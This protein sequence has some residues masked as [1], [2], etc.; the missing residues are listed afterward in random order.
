MYFTYHSASFAPQ[1]YRDWANQKQSLEKSW[2]VAGETHGS[3]LFLG[4]SLGQVFTQQLDEVVSSG[5]Q[6]FGLRLLV[7]VIWQ[8]LGNRKV[9]MISHWCGSMTMTMTVTFRGLCQTDK[10]KKLYDQCGLLPTTAFLKKYFLFNSKY[11]FHLKDLM[12]APV[13]QWRIHVTNLKVHCLKSVLIYHFY[14]GKGLS[15]AQ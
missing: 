8:K 15:S 4:F 14:Y 12:S 10:Q 5:L 6:L 7:R 13:K 9:K 11:F 3:C 2:W 1:T